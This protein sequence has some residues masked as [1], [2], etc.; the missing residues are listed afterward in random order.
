MKSPKFAAYMLLLSLLLLPLYIFMQLF[1][2]LWLSFV[3]LC[4]SGFYFYKTF[5][6]SIYDLMHFRNIYKKACSSMSEAA[7][8][9]HKIQNQVRDLFSE[10]MK[11]KGISGCWVIIKGDDGVF[12]YSIVMGRSREKATFRD[13]GEYFNIK[14]VPDPGPIINEKP[15]VIGIL[16]GHTVVDFPLFDGKVLNGFVGFSGDSKQIAKYGMEN[17]HAI[18]LLIKGMYKNASKIRQME[19]QS[20]RTAAQADS[21]GDELASTNMRLVNRV[22]E[23]K[24]LY[25]LSVAVYSSST[26]EDAAK[27]VFREIS[28]IMGLDEG[29]Y[30]ELFGDR[31][32]LRAASSSS[33]KKKLK[34]IEIPAE[35]LSD[36]RIIEI[37]SLSYTGK[38]KVV[39]DSFNSASLISLPAKVADTIKGVFLLKSRDSDYSARDF[40]ILE[41][42]ASRLAEFIERDETLKTVVNSNRQLEELN[43]VKDNFISLISHELKTPL[44]SIKGFTEL[45]LGGHGGELNEKQ[46]DFVKTIESSVEKLESSINDVIDTASVTRGNSKLNKEKVSVEELIKECVFEYSEIFENK[47]INCKIDLKD[48]FL[49]INVDR[50]KIKKAIKSLL[51][52]AVKFTSQGGKVT[53]AAAGKGDFVQVAVIDSGIGISEKLKKRVFEKFF[54]NQN[55]RTRDMEGMGL[56]L[57]LARSIILGHGGEISIDSAPGGG[58]E[59]T[60]ILPLN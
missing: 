2:I 6:S 58:A 18:S 23:L 15:A 27:T 1:S 31:L 34:E 57:T 10:T 30:F 48:K 36:H 20:M 4:L 13:A 21:A 51:D 8:T 52:N 26:P 3:C 14:E 41:M 16:P 49:E 44:T 55:P 32:R 28:S 12:R 29:A 50:G 38:T 59:V 22:K 40:E 42:Y 17:F 45:L 19:L 54:Q 39:F 37:D 33:L 7:S 46:E 56:G 11:L 35:L 47:N 43:I 25:N 24:S 60:F 9:V 53:V 5:R